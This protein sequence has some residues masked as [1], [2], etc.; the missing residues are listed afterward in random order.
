[1]S[2]PDDLKDDL[3]DKEFAHAYVDE[4][5]N[6]S[7]ATQ[8]KVLREQRK[9]TQQELAELAGMKQERIS[10]LENVDY[11]SWSINTLKKIAKALDVTLKVTFETFGSRLVDISGFTRKSMEKMSREV[12]LAAEKNVGRPQNT[13]M[14]VLYIPQRTSQTIEDTGPNYD[15]GVQQ[16]DQFAAFVSI[17]K[18][19]TPRIVNITIN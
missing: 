6:M 3:A 10:V 15:F 19:I 9:L 1:M 16:S 5:L 14:P 7:I 11:S 8:L 2:I 17:Q 18:A 13:L 4:F 12:E